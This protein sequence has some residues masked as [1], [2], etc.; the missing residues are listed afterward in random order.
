MPA[1]AETGP[2]VSGDGEREHHAER[3]DHQRGTCLQDHVHF[4]RDIQPADDAQDQ[5]W[6]EAAA[7]QRGED[8]DQIEFGIVAVVADRGRQCRDQPGFERERIE[9][10]AQP[11]R[12]QHHEGQQ[13]ARDR[14]QAEQR[15][16]KWGEMCGIM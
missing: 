8:R 2:D 15:G 14:D 9:V 6:Q 1:E 3:A 11:A 4:A 16:G 10:V 12:P 5:V 13:Q 7:K